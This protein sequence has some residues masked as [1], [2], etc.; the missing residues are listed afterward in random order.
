MFCL[1]GEFVG[2]DDRKEER[3]TDGEVD[4]SNES[5]VVGNNDWENVSVADGERD[6]TTDGTNEWITLGKVDGT[7]DGK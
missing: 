6:G 2:S 1:D 5:G 4:G 3:A 7:K